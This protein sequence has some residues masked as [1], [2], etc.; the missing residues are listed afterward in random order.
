VDARACVQVNDVFRTTERLGLRQVLFSP[1]ALYLEDI[2]S[3]GR[4]LLRREERRYEVV[5]GQV[6]GEAHLLSWLQIMEP[7]SVSRDGQ[8]AVITDYGSETNYGVYLARLDGSPAVML[9]SGHAGGI[10]PDDKWVAS[11]L[12]SDATNVLLL[13]TGV[14]ETKTITAPNF[15]YRGAEWASDGRRLVVLASQAD[16]PLRFWV[17]NIDGGAPRP[18][19]PEGLD[20][21]FVTVNHSD[22]IGARDKT[23]AV[24]LYPIDGGDPKRLAGLTETDQVIGGSA[25]SDI[26]YV[27]SGDSATRRQVVK[28]NIANGQRQP[29]VTVSPADSIGIAHVGRP[30][31]SADGKRFVYLQVRQL[32]VLYVATG[33]E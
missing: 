31:F 21:L 28:V 32:S 18:I 30:I 3:D 22:Y 14:G 13:P 5:V 10:S 26:V 27:S 20:G 6:G 15:H 2:A 1:A 33:L 9:G 25:D 4:V 12:P 16:R 29:F 17:Q 11:I 8:Y 23:G 24:G 19:T 7:S